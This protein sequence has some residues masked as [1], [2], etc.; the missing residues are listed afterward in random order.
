[1][2]VT[3]EKSEAW[4]LTD[5]ECGHFAVVEEPDIARHAAIH[6]ALIHHRTGVIIEGVDFHRLPTGQRCDL[7]G[8]V[9]ELPWWEHVADPPITEVDDDNGLW[10]VCDPCH[11]LLVHRDAPALV[12]R[13]WANIEETSPGTARSPLAG[14]LKASLA[15]RMRLTVDRLNEGRRE[16]L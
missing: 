3:G 2:H 6:F 5:D 13:V 16:E 9:M 8:T 11:E 12:A 10:V 4:I 7:C 1:V 14:L 15:D